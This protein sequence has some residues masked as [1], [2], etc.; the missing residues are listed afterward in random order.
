M[1]LQSGPD[2]MGGTMPR[3]KEIQCLWKGVKPTPEEIQQ[4]LADHKEWLDSPRPWDGKPPHNLS[5][6]DLSAANL[7]GANL[8]RANLSLANLKKANLRRA[9]L[10][11]ADLSWADLSW[12][13]LSE[14]FLGW[15]NLSAANLSDAKLNAAKLNGAALSRANLNGADLHEAEVADIIYKKLKSCRGIRADSCYGSLLFRRHV[16]DMSYIE[17]LRGSKWG[18]LYWPWFITSNCG[19]SFS[20]WVGWSVFFALC[21]ALV[22]FFGLGKDAFHLGEGLDFNFTTMLYYSVV[23]FT[24]LGFGD[25]TPITDPAKWWVMAEVVLGYIMLGGLISI[26]ANKFA[27]RAG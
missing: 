19:R 25:V 23:T 4:I 18:W 16:M 15:A 7:S 14:A 9:D 6:T 20:L 12:A 3:N 11:L 21:F 5:E 24:T 8:S 22:F 27:R 17:E 2:L 10:L 13:K 26:F 1:G